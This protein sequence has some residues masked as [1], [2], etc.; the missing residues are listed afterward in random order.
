MS[1]A[2]DPITTKF[3][4]ATAKLPPR[5]RASTALGSQFVNAFPPSDTLAAHSLAVTDLCRY[6]ATKEARQG[7]PAADW[8]TPR[9]ALPMGPGYYLF[10]ATQAPTAPANQP[11]P[12]A[13]PTQAPTQPVPQYQ[14]RPERPLKPGV[15]AVIA[16]IARSLDKTETEH[17][18]RLARKLSPVSLIRGL[19]DLGWSEAKAQA[20]FGYLCAPTT[21]SW[22]DFVES[23]MK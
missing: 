8:Y 3:F 2:F 20:A 13:A 11:Q 12:T 7:L 10:T 17:A 1:H 5:I 6:L 14:P 16:I 21:E 4:P 15:K 22:E 23:V 9:Q 18:I 19:L